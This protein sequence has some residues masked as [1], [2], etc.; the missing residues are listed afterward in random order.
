[1]DSTAMYW[2]VHLIMHM[3]GDKE[4]HSQNVIG[5][6]CY[7]HTAGRKTTVPVE[8]MACVHY[9]ARFSTLRN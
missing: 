2:A 8:S 5:C 1:V 7:H 4:A 9:Q 6:S 3:Q